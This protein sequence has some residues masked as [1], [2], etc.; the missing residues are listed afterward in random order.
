MTHCA[1]TMYV[2]G[3]STDH[4]IILGTVQKEVLNLDAQLYL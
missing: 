3:N 2:F 1:V 4:I